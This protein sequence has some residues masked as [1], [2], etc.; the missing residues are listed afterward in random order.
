MPYF[1]RRSNR[2]TRLRLDRIAK[3]IPKIRA[4]CVTVVSCGLISLAAMQARAGMVLILGNGSDANTQ[5]A[6][7]LLDAN[8]QTAT[9]G[10][11]IS[12]FTAAGGA[13]GSLAG[14]NAVVLL[15]GDGTSDGYVMPSTGQSALLSFI[16]GGGG[17]VTAEWSN[18]GYAALGY[19][20]TL[21]AALPVVPSSDYDFVTG[22][23]YTQST[24]DSILDKNL[25]SSFAFTADNSGGT[26]NQFAPKPGAFLYFTSS[27]GDS[28]DG[29]IGWGYGSGRVI[30]F[31]TL[32]G[33]DEL[34][35]PN[36]S[37]LFANAVNWSQEGVLPEPVG[38]VFV[39]SLAMTLKRRA[40]RRAG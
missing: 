2:A 1:R 13:G 11:A 27:G 22:L 36:Y 23:T 26:E 31:S 30:S 14:Y 40:R 7:T 18:W 19:N 29:L 37:V 6:Q 33:P 25:P 38:I 21:E 34:S 17:L 12:N 4:V 5:A 8:G 39:L 9:I 24:P 28:P 35:D 3:A 16:S 15:D 32:A 10:P 20:S